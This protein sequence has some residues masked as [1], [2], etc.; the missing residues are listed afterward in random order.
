MKKMKTYDFNAEKTFSL[1][2]YQ[3]LI[4]AESNGFSE[5]KWVVG[6]SGGKDSTVTAAL[7]ARI[8]GRENVVGVLMP[9]G[10][11]PDISDAE[12][13]V[14]I[15]GIKRVRVNIGKSF[16]DITG[17]FESPENSLEVS[18]DSKINLP[19][20]LRMS[21][22]YAVAQSVD[23]IV[24]NTSNLT[25]NY[26]SFMT[27]YGDHA[28]SYG[29]IQNLTVTEVIKLGEWLGLPE[30]LVWKTPVDGLQPLTDEE[31]LG[32]RYYNVDE[33]IRYGRLF[34][35][36]EKIYEKYCS[37]KFKLEIVNI[38]GPTFDFPDY[39]KRDF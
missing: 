33:F 17:Q 27:L 12:E 2:K 22:L 30:K 20:R 24:L 31:K 1:L 6:I 3:W 8:F 9:C 11:Q 28:G 32:M 34:V 37:G 38:P 29:P 35:D 10:E 13:A 14:Q 25:E 19:A 39:V 4:W 7:A 23:G 36:P 21:T 18:E 5:K 26:L 16:A 15:L